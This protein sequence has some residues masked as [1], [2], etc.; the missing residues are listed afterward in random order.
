MVS[1]KW[2]LCG[3]NVFPWLPMR[4]N[5]F[6]F[7]WY[8][9]RI[10]FSEIFSQLFFFYFLSS[11][12]FPCGYAVLY[13][14]WILLIFCPFMC[15]KNFLTGCC[16]PFEFLYGDLLFIFIYFV[17]SDVC[18]FHIFRSFLQFRIY[19]DGNMESLRVIK[20]RDETS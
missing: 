17:I 16:L 8:W 2:D 13:S 12:F 3:F 7:I 18:W 1:V 14:C 5:I 6:S 11:Y 4:L 9:S 20:S 10:I 15:H 19:S